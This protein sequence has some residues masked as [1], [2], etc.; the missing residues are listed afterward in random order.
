MIPDPRQD[1]QDWKDG[2]DRLIIASEV[3][4]QVWT[5]DFSNAE[6]RAIRRSINHRIEWLK[7]HGKW[8]Y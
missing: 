1:R 3:M 7:E 4:G 2:Q 5:G 8:P 6:L